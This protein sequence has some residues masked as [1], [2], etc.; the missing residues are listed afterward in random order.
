MHLFALAAS[1]FSTFL[2]YAVFILE[3]LTKI[4]EFYV[5]L[6]LQC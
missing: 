6:F 4:K 5:I 3:M 1:F 2:H